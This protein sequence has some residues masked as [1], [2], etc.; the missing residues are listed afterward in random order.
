MDTAA[1]VLRTELDL[2]AARRPHHVMIDG[3]WR[4]KNGL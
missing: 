4:V 3:E 1:S 2:I